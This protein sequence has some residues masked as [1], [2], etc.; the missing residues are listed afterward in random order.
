M[1]DKVVLV[2]DDDSSILE[3]LKIV[4]EESNFK[5]IA[6]DNGVGIENVVIETKPHIMLLD[7]W[8]PGLDGKEILQTIKQNPKTAHIPIIIMSASNGLA[9][10]AEE[11]KADGFLAKPFNIEDLENTITRFLQ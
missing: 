11:I 1:S 10:T 8:I 6:L 2:V 4:L 7:L 9:Q 3:V 5:V